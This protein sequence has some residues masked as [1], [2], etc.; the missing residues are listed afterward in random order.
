MPTIDVR[1]DLLFKAIGKE[2]SDEEFEELCFDFGLEL[3]EVITEGD[4]GK[5]EVVIY[6]IEIPANRYDLLCLEGISRGIQ[7][8]M[9]K[10]KAPRYKTIYPDGGLQR[11]KMSKNTALVRPHCVAALLRNI[12]FTKASYDSFIDLQD[13]LHH[14]LCR[15]R[16]LVAIG[17]HDFDT[18]QGP[19]LYDALPPQDIKFKPLNQNKEFTAVELMELYKGES[20]LKQYL[21]IIRDKPVYPVIFDANGVVLSMPPII[22]GEHSKITM[23][24]RNVFIESTATDLHKA[25]IV[26]DTLV[27]MFSVYCDEPFVTE[28]VEVE[29]PDGSVVVYPELRYRHEVVCVE[30]I[31][32]NIGIKESPERLADLLTRMCLLSEVTDDGKSVRVEI[33]PTRA[34]IIHECDIIE[35]VAISYGFNNVVKTIPPTNTIANQF[36]LNTLCDLLRQEIAQA[37]FTEVLTFALCSRDD[38]SEKLKKSLSLSKAVHIANPKTLEF[39]VARTTLIPGILKTV[40]C[41]KKM[42]LPMKLF[43]I[44][45]V[46]HSDERKDVGARNHRRFCAINYNK[47]PGFEVIH[48]LL[49]RTMQLLEVSYTDDKTSTTGYYLKAHEDGTFFPGRCA[50][51]IAN[52]RQ[53]GIMGV[54]HPD[55]VHNFELNLPC[56]ILELDVEEFL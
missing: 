43:E 1:R 29:Q 55:V 33:P 8:F 3:D 2:Y 38:V 52:G 36:K 34:D 23:K 14:N 37:G 35:D 18:I 54:L 41:N 32:K 12:T 25:K 31:N 24:T 26:L 42:P 22:N 6:K 56:A 20:H 45:D 40:S 15:R 44:S 28:A 17:T 50:L 47:T 16:S 21:S 49:D 53:I 13:K 19:F 5:D 51:V 9:G 30:Q 7:I 27:T 4:S 10:I 48:G 39:Q 46:V 11:L